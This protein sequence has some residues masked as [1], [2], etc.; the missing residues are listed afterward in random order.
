MLQRVIATLP[1]L[2]HHVQKWLHRDQLCLDVNWLPLI[3][4]TIIIRGACLFLHNHFCYNFFWHYWSVDP[5]YGE[6]I[7]ATG[8]C[9]LT[10]SFP[11][12]HK[13]GNLTWHE[14]SQCNLT[15]I[16]TECEKLGTRVHQTCKNACTLQCL[17]MK[18]NDHIQVDKLFLVQ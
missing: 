4:P 10:P 17:V 7:Y 5:T 8:S 11:K 16:T 12:R 13:Q 2:W 3:A 1:D 9:L 15:K 14:K 6:K 18:S